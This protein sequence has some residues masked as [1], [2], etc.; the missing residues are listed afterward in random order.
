MQTNPNL[1]SFMSLSILFSWGDISSTW[2]SFNLEILMSNNEIPAITQTPHQSPDD[3]IWTPLTSA[4][5]GI[6]ICV[7]PVQADLAVPAGGVSLTEKTLAGVGVTGRRVREVSHAAT[8]AGLAGATRGQR[9]AVVTRTTPGTQRSG[10]RWLLAPGEDGWK[11]STQN[12][13][14][15][16]K[17]KQQWIADDEKLRSFQ[18]SRQWNVIQ[19][20]N[21]WFL[22]VVIL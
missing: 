16:T 3:A 21:V 18:S 15:V 1:D 4:L 9:G 19:Q 13:G 17:K 8:V 6:S 22:V 14:T 11:S 10:Q 20:Q 2:M 7:E 5:P 12:T